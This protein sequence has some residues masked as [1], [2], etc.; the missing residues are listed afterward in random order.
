MA[1][2][3]DFMAQV[4]SSRILRELTERVPRR[5]I[6]HQSLERLPAKH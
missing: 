3:K 2:K 5:G 1:E 6:F 4:A